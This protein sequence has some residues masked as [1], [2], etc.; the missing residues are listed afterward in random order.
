MRTLTLAAVL[1]LAGC[2]SGG[3]RNALPP[4][5]EVR[6]VACALDGA[7]TFQQ[8]CTTEKTSGAEGTI[9]TIRHPD[10]GFRRFRILPDGRGLE[11]ADGFDE[12]RISLLSDKRIEVDAGDDRYILPAR[13]R[14]A[15]APAE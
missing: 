14:P 10:G 7:A 5:G 12:T 8:R 13:L 4:Q 2:D 9:L 15:G 11:A 6:Q 1:L 3:D